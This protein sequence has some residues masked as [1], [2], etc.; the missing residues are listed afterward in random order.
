MN[1]KNMT[2]KKW[3]GLI[4]KI[5]LALVAATFAGAESMNFF[6]FVFPADQWYL[7]YTAFAMTMGAMFV[8]LYLLLNDAETPLQRTVALIMMLVGLAGEIFSAGFG[9]QIESW[10]K[11]GFALAESDFDFMI[12]VVRIMIAVQGLALMLYWTGDQIFEL[13]KDDDKDGKANYRDKDYKQQN[14]GSNNQSQMLRNEQPRRQDARADETRPEPKPQTNYTLAD[15]LAKM[16]RND[17]KKNKGSGNQSQ[18]TNSTGR[19]ASNQGGVT[20]FTN[21]EVLAKMNMTLEQAKV[22]YGGKRYDDFARDC[23]QAFG[24]VE[25]NGRNMKKVFYGDVNPT[26]AERNGNRV[27]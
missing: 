1:L 15:Y 19:N 14:K 12:L 24:S 7:S 20:Q 21:E 6:N 3:I 4:L 13:L 11:A 9:M 18:G 2:V 17:K 26:Q 22:K 27:P 5:G 10:K 16:L 25:I 23:S 8:Y